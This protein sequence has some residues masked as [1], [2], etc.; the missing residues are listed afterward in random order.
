ML[1]YIPTLI[2]FQKIDLRIVT[3]VIIFKKPDEIAED[4]FNTEHN[5]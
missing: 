4:F 1:S 3:L 5:C 2:I